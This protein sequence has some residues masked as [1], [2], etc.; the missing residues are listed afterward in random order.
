MFCEF[1]Y[2]PSTSLT[3]KNRQKLLTE[4]HESRPDLDNLVKFVKDCG[5]GTM[6]KDDSQVALVS[7][8]KMYRDYEGTTIW[9]YR[10]KELRGLAER[11]ARQPRHSGE[12]EDD[13]DAGP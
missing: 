3:V 11:V 7:A 5:T 13:G 6:Y 1:A 9:L 2:V 12:A 8:C 4:L 10:A